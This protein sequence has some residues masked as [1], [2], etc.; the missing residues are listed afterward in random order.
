ML[1]VRGPIEKTL[2]SVALQ[3]PLKRKIEPSFCFWQYHNYILRTRLKLEYYSFILAESNILRKQ[4]L[5][6]PD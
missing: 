6:Q 2:L 5:S 3:K 1:L 4:I